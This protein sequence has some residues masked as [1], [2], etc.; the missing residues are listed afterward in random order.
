MD[1]AGRNGYADDPGGGMPNVVV[2]PNY[3]GDPDKVEVTVEDDAPL[4][5]LDIFSL[6]GFDIGARAVASDDSQHGR[7][8][9]LRRQRFLQYIRPFHHE[10]LG[11]DRHGT[12]AQQ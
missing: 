9:D 7:I 2:T 5:F 10:R 12:R 1:Y 6:G 8:C 4:L 11:S 3:N